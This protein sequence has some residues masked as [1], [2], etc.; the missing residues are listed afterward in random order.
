MLGRL[1]GCGGAQ[2]DLEKYTAENLGV[3]FLV[4]HDDTGASR[5]C[6]QGKKLGTLIYHR[7]YRSAFC[8]TAKCIALNVGRLR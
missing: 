8:K 6:A 5:C 4:G 2:L 1:G 3:V 7:R